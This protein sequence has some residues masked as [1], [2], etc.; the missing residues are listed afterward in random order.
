MQTA[1]QFSVRLVNKPGRLAAVLSSL[2]KEKV[3]LLALTVV[4]STDRSTLR[5]VPDDPLAAGAALEAM[6][7][8]FDEA[9]VLLADLSN[10]NGAFQH[11]CERLA[12]EHV[13][14]DYAYGSASGR[15]QKG[16]ALAVLKVNDAAKAQ[17]VLAATPANGRERARPVRRRPARAR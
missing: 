14:I 9:E 13:N 15:A 17:R 5:F 3:H 10:Q 4:D 1:K 12:G 2:A 6:N 7:V 11:L 8:A 16:A